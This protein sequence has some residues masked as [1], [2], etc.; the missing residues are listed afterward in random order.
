[1]PIV[2]VAVGT[3]AGAVTSRTRAILNDMLNGNPLGDIFNDSQPYVVEFINSAIDILNTK[4]VDSD[5]EF[6]TNEFIMYG[7]PATGDPADPNATTYIDYV[8]CN[9]GEANFVYPVLPPD[10]MMPLKI[11]A[12]QNGT[13]AVFSEIRGVADGL[14]AQGVAPFAA[15]QWDWFQNTLYITGSQLSLDL[16]VRYIVQIPYIS[17][18]SEWIPVQNGCEALAYLCAGKFEQSRGNPIAST[19]LDVANEA[20]DS[21]INRTQRRKARISHK[22]RWRH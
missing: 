13:N 17:E 18:I 3:L 8:G 20:I 5:L 14:Q 6:N 9:N 16:R 12:R 1:M 15:V 7:L 4:F 11:W 10:L 22:R 21:I 2:P 19:F